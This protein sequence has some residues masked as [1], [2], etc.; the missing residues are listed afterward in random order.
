MER[1][2]RPGAT[3]H[4]PILYGPCNWPQRLS[5]LSAKRRALLLSEHGQ[6]GDVGAWRQYRVGGDRL[7]PGSTGVTP[8]WGSSFDLYG[9][10]RELGWRKHGDRDVFDCR[11][12]S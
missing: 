12:T 4:C 3:Q 1:G 11:G 5:H 7:E 8:K 10:D 9:L 2:G 6:H